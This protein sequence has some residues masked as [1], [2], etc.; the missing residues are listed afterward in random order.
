MIK[1]IEGLASRETEM[2]FLQKYNIPIELELI[3]R[4]L[5]N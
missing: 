2:R 1:T 4:L 3:H 5:T